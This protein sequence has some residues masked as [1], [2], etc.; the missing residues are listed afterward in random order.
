MK[1]KSIVVSSVDKKASGEKNG[2]PWTLYQITDQDGVKYGTFEKQL[3]QL[4]I[5]ARI[6]YDEAEKEFVNK[7]GKSVKYIQR[8]IKKFQVGAQHAPVEPT[9][10]LDERVSELEKNLQNLK[11][12][13]LTSVASPVTEKDLSEVDPNDLPF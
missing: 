6:S 7:E 5:P 8:T 12:M 9:K 3:A 2:K 13:F 11:D 4:D 1:D 10:T